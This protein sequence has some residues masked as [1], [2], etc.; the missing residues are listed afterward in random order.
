MLRSVPPH[1]VMIQADVMPD[2]T[3]VEWKLTVGGV[4]CAT[5]ETEEDLRP[6]EAMGDILASLRAG[7]T[8]FE[9]TKTDGGTT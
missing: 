2:G 4:A 1:P 6:G 3:K 7:A 8:V 5:F 9:R